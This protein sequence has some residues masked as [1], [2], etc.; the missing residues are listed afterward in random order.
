MPLL[1][2]FLAALVLLPPF[3]DMLEEKK[4]EGREEGRA[5][6]EQELEDEEDYYENPEAYDED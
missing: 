5:E 1:I 3:L 6:K 2:I 4:E